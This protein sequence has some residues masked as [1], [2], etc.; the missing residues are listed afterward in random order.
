[1]HL[2]EREKLCQII[3]S[4]RELSDAS[5]R[6][7][8][9]TASFKSL[10]KRDLL[11]SQDNVDHSEFFLLSGMC[12]SLIRDADGREVTLGFTQGPGVVPPNIARTREGTS[13]VDIE[14]LAASEV[15]VI[16]SGKLAELMFSDEEIREWGNTVLRRELQRMVAREWSLAALSAQEKLEWFRGDFPE[17]EQ[18]F[19]HVHIASYLGITPVTLSRVRSRR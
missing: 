13:L 17:G 10:A 5:R 16:D 9:D 11:A 14:M 19:S 2:D 8:C 4:I 6:K 12:R 15:A 18:T 7:L 1:M 3:A